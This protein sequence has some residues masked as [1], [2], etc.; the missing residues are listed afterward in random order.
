LRQLL[1]QVCYFSLYS[2]IWS[3]FD[4]LVCSSELQP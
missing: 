1:I 2:P 4:C 3:L